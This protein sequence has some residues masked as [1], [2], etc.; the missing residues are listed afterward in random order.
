MIIL[1]YNQQTKTKLSW[2]RKINYCNE[3]TVQKV[4]LVPKG[5]KAHS[6]YINPEVF[7]AFVFAQIFLQ[8]GIDLQSLG[9]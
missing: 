7:Q 5:L 8:L 4:L 2:Q 3:S 9:F 6:T 1:I